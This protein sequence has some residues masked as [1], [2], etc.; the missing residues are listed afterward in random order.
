MFK[1][2][3]KHPLL[4]ACLIAVVNSVSFIL[5]APYAP[6][7]TAGI[8]L[9]LLAKFLPGGLF[10]TS[11]ILQ[12]YLSEASWKVFLISFTGG[13]GTIAGSFISA[14]T[15]KNFRVRRPRG[16]VAARSFLGGLLMG[17]GVAVTHGCNLLHILGGT[18]LLV[19]AS[20]LASIAIMV[21]AYA[22]LLLVLKYESGL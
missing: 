6:S 13:V 19:S 14:L 2:L 18:P 22:T 17:L 9:L 10:G 1:D 3:V 21:G 11:H 12:Y 7:A 20:I 5:I 16:E 4:S 8:G 15:S